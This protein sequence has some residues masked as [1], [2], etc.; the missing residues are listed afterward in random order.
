VLTNRRRTPVI[1][2][3]LSVP[4]PRVDEFG[5]AYYD[6]FYGRGSVH[7]AEQI[8]KLANAVHSLLAWWGLD[9][10]SVLDVG[11]GPGFWRDWYRTHHP[12]VKVLSTDISEYACTTYGHKRADIAVWTPPRKFDLVVCHSVLQYP[13]NSAARSAIDNLAA[14]ARHFM[15]LEVPTATDFDEVV[16][17]QLTDMSVRRRSGTWYRRELDRHFRQVGGGLW[18]ARTSNIPMYELEMPANDRP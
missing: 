11:A 15:Y 12:D 13:D 1:C 7:N 18:L 4:E 14:G 8:D 9:V 16:D 17:P 5:A 2:Y 3:T 6:R 10:R